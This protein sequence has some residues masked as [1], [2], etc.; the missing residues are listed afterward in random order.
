[1]P[2]LV[3]HPADDLVENDN[4]PDGDFDGFELADMIDSDSFWLLF[5]ST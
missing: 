3:S 5:E 1:M 4:D 2:G